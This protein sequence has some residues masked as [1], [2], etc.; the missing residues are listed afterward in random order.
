RAELEGI[1]RGKT[2]SNNQGKYT[3]RYLNF[4]SQTEIRIA[5]A[6][7]AVGVLFFPNSKARL[8]GP[9]G[10][11]NRIPDFLVCKDGKWGILEVD[12]EEW[13]PATRAVHDHARDRYFV[14]HGIRVVQHFDATDCY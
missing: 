13:H 10:R 7:D 6:L 8:N 5:Q 2:V 11:E 4:A 12:G 14:K 3:W 1:A 9:D